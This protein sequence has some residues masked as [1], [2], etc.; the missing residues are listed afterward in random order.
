LAVMVPWLTPI[1]VAVRGLPKLA[2][3]DDVNLPLYMVAV[4]VGMAGK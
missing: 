2:L 1:T 3:N 4:F